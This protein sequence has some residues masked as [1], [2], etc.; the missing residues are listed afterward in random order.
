[1]PTLKD[2]INQKLIETIFP[3]VTENQ[4][5]ANYNFFHTSVSKSNSTI[6]KRVNITTVDE[7]NNEKHLTTDEIIK[8]YPLENHTM[9]EALITVLQRQ[10]ILDTF[11]FLTLVTP[12]NKMLNCDFFDTTQIT[13]N[14][15]KD[16]AYEN[17]TL[18]QAKQ[19]FTNN[20]DIKA[21]HSFIKI[22]RSIN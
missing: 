3:N 5:S 15:L 13:G 10:N 21:L 6:Q 22:I 17:T 7:N 2:L 4:P 18:K 12:D 14:N 16:K 8:I 20:E 9:Y 11:Y 1:M 19:T